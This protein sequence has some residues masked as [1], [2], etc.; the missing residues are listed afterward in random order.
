M[1]VRD[2]LGVIAQVAATAAPRLVTAAVPRELRV[3]PCERKS[4]RR[5]FA[6]WREGV[7]PPLP[8]LPG[9]R[10]HGHGVSIA[11]LLLRE[12]RGEVRKNVRFCVGDA[13]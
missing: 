6:R 8:Q 7:W 13:P 5:E 11:Y 1:L 4:K 3:D 12:R 10:Y 9:R 2:Q